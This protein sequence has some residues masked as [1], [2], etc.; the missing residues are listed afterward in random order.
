MPAEV[1]D[2][3]IDAQFI[4]PMNSHDTM[5]R[6]HSLLIRDGHI[7]E[8]LPTDEAQRRYQAAGVVER[9][10]HLLLP[11]LINADAEAAMSLTRVMGEQDAAGIAAR[12]GPEFVYDS[13]LRAMAEMLRSGVTC[14]LDRFYAPQESAQAVHDQGMRAVVGL[15]LTNTPSPWAANA[16]EYLSRALKLRDEYRSHPL[17]TTCFAPLDVHRLADEPL[18]R[19]ATLADELEAGIAVDLSDGATA[20]CGPLTRLKELNLLTPSFTA[21]HPKALAADELAL[22]QRAG[23]GFCLSPQLTLG[24][25]GAA[26][27]A[28][29]AESGVKLAIASAGA[30]TLRYDVW[31]EMRIAASLLKGAG[32][33]HQA[34]ALCT[35]A[36]ATALGLEDVGTLAPGKWAD[37]CCLDLSHPATFAGREDLR[38]IVCCADRDCV[39]D[40]WVAGRAL[41]SNRELVRLDWQ[42]VAAK[43]RNW[44]LLLNQ[45]AQR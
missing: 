38:T 11:G 3:R 16:G 30:R 40:V 25:R 29:L 15:P 14:F 43:A 42:A 5:L 19:L 31:G 20:E 18:R 13:V 26:S 39:S 1:A 27:I 23:I 12:L 32:G 44:S 7:V 6:A 45:G 4:V 22:A 34:L 28:A 33:A 2:L 21:L 35:S 8:I 36:A 10:A 37:I 24:S 17:I 41:L 9:K